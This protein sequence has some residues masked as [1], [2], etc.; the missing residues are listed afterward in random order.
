MELFIGVI[1]AFFLGGA[2]GYLLRATRDEP[3]PRS[4][5]RAGVAAAPARQGRRAAAATGSRTPSV[6]AKAAG[7]GSGPGSDAGPRSG[8]ALPAEGPIP[9]LR[10]GPWDRSGPITVLVAD[11][12]LEL[13][14][15]HSATLARHG[16]RVLTATDGES[17][18]ALARSEHPAIAVLDH[19]MPGRTGIEVTRALKSDPAT[20]DIVVLLMTAHSYGAVGPSAR[21]A[22]VAAFMAKPC[23]PRRLVREIAAHVGPAEPGPL[24]PVGPV[25]SRGP[26][27]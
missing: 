5:S 10:L 14:A 24:G 18:L 11:D 4:A 22:G 25:G 15:L 3:L 1:V 8:S 21:E 7:P 19:S 27:H 17:A 20:A 12:R 23:D 13:V 26:A 6:A 2:S 16:Y 9:T